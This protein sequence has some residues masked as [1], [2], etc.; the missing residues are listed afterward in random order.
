M[1]SSE[2]TRTMIALC[3]AAFSS[4][5]TEFILRILFCFDKLDKH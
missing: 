2:H 1:T 5:I 4:T 3:L